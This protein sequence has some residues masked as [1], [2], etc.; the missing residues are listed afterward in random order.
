MSVYPSVLEAIGNTP[1][2]RLN[3]VSEATGCTILGKAEFLNPGQSVKDRA[4]LWIIREAEKAGQLRPGG[5]IVE[6]TAGNTG[7][8]L[9]V[10]G[11]ALGY[12]T[13]IVIPET[14]SQEKK[15]ALRLLGAELVEVPAVPYKNP[16]NYV[17]VSGR[18]AAELAKTDPNGAIWANQFDNVANREAHVQTT[19]PEIWRDTD[20]KV[21]GFICAV[22]SGGTIAGVAEGLRAKNPAV[23]IG[24]ADPEGAALYNYYAHGELKAGGSSITEGIGQGRVTANLEGFT[25]DFAYQIPDSEAVPYVFDLI[26]K[27]GLCVGGSSGIN[28]AGAVRLAR[29][30]G[31]GHTIVTILCDYGNRYQS[32]LFNPDFLASKGLPVPAWLNRT[33]NITVPYEP[34]G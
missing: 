8:G 16:N 22:G 25:P 26:E 9:A 4:A 24:I 34:V 18:L 21:D 17:K 3:A 28:I 30:L 29:E 19:A 1:L 6:G 5:V 27:E 32:K 20:G 11:S 31:P 23:K 14:Q 12:R 2:I 10:V 15:D 13:V 7:I 33:S